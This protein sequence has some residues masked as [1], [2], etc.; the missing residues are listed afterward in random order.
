MVVNHGQYGQHHFLTIQDVAAMF[1]VSRDY[2]R[3]LLREGFLSGIKLP[4]EAKKTPIR[5]TR[6][7]V[8]AFIESHK[9]AGTATPGAPPKRKKRKQY[10]G[11][12]TK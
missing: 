10:H 2:V 5:I 7:S 3:R 12:F 6:T 9:L 4:G 11:P 1:N 8:D